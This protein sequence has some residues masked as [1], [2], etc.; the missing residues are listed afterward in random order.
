MRV[1][2]VFRPFPLRA[3]SL[4]LPAILSACAANAQLP[5]ERLQ[6][7]RSWDVD[8]SVP[9]APTIASENGYSKVTFS[10][11]FD[12]SL[13][14]R[15]WWFR[16]WW[17]R[18][19]EDAD[20]ARA[21][22]ANGVLHLQLKPVDGQWHDLNITSISPGLD[23]GRC[24]RYGYF[25]ARIKLPAGENVWPAF[26]LISVPHAEDSTQPAGEIDILEGSSSH[27]S[28]ILTTL[29]RAS[30]RST[31]QYRHNGVDLPTRVADDFHIYGA[32]WL[33]DR[34]TWY[35]DG[36]EINS[37]P[38]YDT[39][40]QPMMLIL[41]MGPGDIL[42]DRKGVPK[43]QAD[44]ANEMLVDWVRAWQRPASSPPP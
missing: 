22:A 5:S 17:Q 37:A 19:A 1:L 26:W 11:E 4:L 2:S 39:S 31:D 20:P 15:K 36:K 41:G 12:S 34:V 42:G 9:T 38:T 35:V 25:E 28:A 43:D 29:H 23:A 14:P 30:D 27:P 44:G 8:H 40:S 6:E 32:L 33:P 13:D 21:F 3:F 16:L 18:P 10:D 24:F 7:A